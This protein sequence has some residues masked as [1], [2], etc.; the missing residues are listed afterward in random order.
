MAADCQFTSGNLTTHGCKIFR[1]KEDI[2]AFAGDQQSGLLFVDWLNGGDKPELPLEDFEAI[3]LTKA[4]KMIYY[5]DKLKPA[6]VTESHVAIGSGSHLA[7]G[8]M[9]EGASPEKAVKIACKRDAYSSGPVKAY[10]RKIIK[11][12][13]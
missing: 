11:K 3:V 7:I 4:G 13:K 6:P 9:M 2:A 10:N 5:G 1:V 8:A 12:V